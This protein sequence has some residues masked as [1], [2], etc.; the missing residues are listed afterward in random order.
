MSLYYHEE[1]LLRFSE[2]GSKSPKDWQAFQAWFSGVF[3]PGAV[4]TEDKTLI[5]LA[6]AHVLDSPCLIDAYTEECIEKGVTIEQMT[7]AIHVAAAIRAAST[8]MHGVQ[9]R[10]SA[11]KLGR[12]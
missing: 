7:E 5:A 6:V 1:D 9:M 12:R 4:T 11:E 2:F 8:M 10:K 3:A